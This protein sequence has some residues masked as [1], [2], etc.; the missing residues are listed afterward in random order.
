[1]RQPSHRNISLIVKYIS[2]SCV[3][4]YDPTSSIPEQ[5]VLGKKP[6]RSPPSSFLVFFQLNLWQQHSHISV[7]KLQVLFKDEFS[8]KRLLLAFLVPW[9]ALPVCGCVSGNCSWFLCNIVRIIILGILWNETKVI[10]TVIAKYTVS[11]KIISV[12]VLAEC[13]DQATV[14]FILIWRSFSGV[15]F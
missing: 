7:L 2:I 14:L 15:L 3:W 9:T 8:L 4:P 5:Y 10:V 12:I 11:A 6:C 13:C 1:M